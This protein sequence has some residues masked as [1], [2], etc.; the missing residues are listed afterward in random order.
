MLTSPRL[1]MPRFLDTWTGKFVWIDDPGSVVYAILSHTWRSVEDGG[2]QSY[3]DVRKL[4]DEMEDRSGFHIGTQAAA[5]NLTTI[6]H[7]PRL[8][9]KIQ[10]ACRVAREAGYRLIWID[11]CCIDK[12]SSAE[13]SEA[14]N[15]MYEWYRL[16][17]ICYAVLEDFPDGEDPT[18]KS[19]HFWACKWMGR[20]WTLQEL[21]APERVEFLTKTWKPLGSKLEL[22]PLLEE[23][24][25]V[26]LKILTGQAAVDSVSVAQRMSWAAR[27]ETTRVEDQAYCLL[28]LFGVHMPTIY[29]EGRNAFVR[30]QEEIIKTIPDQSIFAWGSPGVL[31]LS[32]D[33]DDNSH[34]KIELDNTSPHTYPPGLLAESPRDFVHPATEIVDTLDG[35]R[36][37]ALLEGADPFPQRPYALSDVIPILQQGYDVVPISPVQFEKRVGKPPTSLHCV[38]TP[39]GVRLK[40]FWIN[41]ASIPHDLLSFPFL[42]CPSCTEDHRYFDALAL[43][44]CQDVHGRLI[45][46][47]LC[48]P[49]TGAPGQEGRTIGIALQSPQECLSCETPRGPPLYSSSNVSH[50]LRLVPE[51]LD[52]LLPYLEPEAIEF[53]LLRYYTDPPKPKS[54]H[55]VFSVYR[56]PWDEPANDI[57]LAPRCAERLTAKGFMLSPL[58]IERQDGNPEESNITIT[59]SLTSTRLRARGQQIIQLKLEFNT[60]KGFITSTTCTR[61]LKNHIAPPVDTDTESPLLE[62]P[63]NPPFDSPLGAPW[64]CV[65]DE[66]D[67]TV[68][69]RY[70]RVFASTDFVV[71][72]IDDSDDQVSCKRARVLRV[73][74]EQPVRYG[75]HR[76]QNMGVL[77]LSFEL[78]GTYRTGGRSEWGPTPIVPRAIVRT[79]LD[80]VDTIFATIAE[81]T[82]QRHEMKALPPKT[83]AFFAQMGEITDTKLG[84]YLPERQ[85]QGL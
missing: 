69:D 35:V 54:R 22:A 15:S 10:E 45:V 2:E 43:L 17:D 53:H 52:A 30:L 82:G 3:T 84:V 60:T 62:V 71:R 26:D 20:G 74:V 65:D 81:K 34:A 31:T 7:H 61:A 38:L 72:A 4:Q 21:I 28:G 79:V 32:R 67:R 27:R 24:T 29:G 68:L 78:S 44:Q 50:S 83:A 42:T 18:D 66:D 63:P 39:Q 16:S 59:T 64:E 73:A 23:V 12:S 11:S 9:N 14:I 13:L 46:L 41:I 5:L 25:R 19:S 55:R 49:M 1:Q 85:R 80:D 57:Q 77:W 58:K 47:P 40:L 6:F 36:T 48:R 51:V 8:C 75:K 70:V 37:N 33:D 76:T 56:D